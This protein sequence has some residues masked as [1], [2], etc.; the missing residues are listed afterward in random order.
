MERVTVENLLS[1][2]QTLNGKALKTAARGAEFTVEVSGDVF[3]FTP[4]S[5][6]KV[7]AAQGA[8]VNA[9][10]EYFNKTGSLRVAD[11]QDIT[12]N[13]SYVLTLIAHLLET[14]EAAEH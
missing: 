7:R 10:C 11:Y 5:S 9:V 6:H 12:Y 13:A 8:Y 1:L 4:L 3:L 2:A 14:E